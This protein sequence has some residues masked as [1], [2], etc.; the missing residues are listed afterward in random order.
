MYNTSIIQKIPSATSLPNL[1]SATAIPEELRW[2]DSNCGTRTIVVYCNSGARAGVAI[3]RL[4][5]LGFGGDP[6]R[7]TIYNGQG[8]V[9]WTQ[10]GYD[11]V[12]TASVVPPSGCHQNECSMA[13]TNDP[14][15]RKNKKDCAAFL[16]TNK[17][18]KCLKKKQTVVVADSCPAICKKQL[19]KCEDRKKPIQVTHRNPT[20]KKK[21]KHLVTCAQIK[22]K[23]WCKKKNTS[24]TYKLRDI[25]PVSC[26]TPCLN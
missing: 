10:A 12:T 20:T 24:K 9:Q 3:A 16:Q 19:C 5:D 18:N 7:T 25:C 13:C 2:C 21:K 22:N 8:I 26:G 23:G 1:Q 15:F 11:V 6:D 4:Y 17:H 14:N